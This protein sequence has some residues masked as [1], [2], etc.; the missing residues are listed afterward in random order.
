MLL[1]MIAWLQAGLCIP[2][3]QQ[4][5]ILDHQPQ[6]WNMNQIMSSKAKTC[7]QTRTCQL[8]PNEMTKHSKLSDQRKQ[9]NQ[10]KQ[11]KLNKSNQPNKT[12]QTNPTKRTKQFK[13]TKQNQENN[14]KLHHHICFKRG[15]SGHLHP[16]WCRG[17]GG[18][19]GG[20]VRDGQG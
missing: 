12:N 6:S 3:H 17:P 18:G 2:Q 19:V 9:N 15:Y 20:W 8:K 16:D 13:Q 5:L 11:S 1:R 4:L 7:K 10:T 14:Q